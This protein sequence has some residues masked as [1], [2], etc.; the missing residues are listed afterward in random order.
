VKAALDHQKGSDGTGFEP[1]AAGSG[2]AT[3]E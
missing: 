3:A 1:A 2:E